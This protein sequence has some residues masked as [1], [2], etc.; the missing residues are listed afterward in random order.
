MVVVVVY[1]GYEEVHLVFDE[2][3]DL[4]TELCLDRILALAAQIGGS[5]ADATG[6]EGIPLT[7][8]LSSYVAGRLVDGLSLEQEIKVNRKQQ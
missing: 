8:N 2:D 4:F 1:L 5:L 3:L 6:D 7:S